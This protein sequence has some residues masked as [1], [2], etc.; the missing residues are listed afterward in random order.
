MKKTIIS[1]LSIL[2]LSLLVCNVFA[3]A[4][5]RTG[6]TRGTSPSFT[7][8]S[9][10]SPTPKPRS[11]STTNNT[12]KPASYSS[13]TA[14]YP[15]ST[16]YFSGD[17]LSNTLIFGTILLMLNDT[18]DGEPTYVDEEGNVYT[19]ADLEEMEVQIPEDEPVEDDLY[20]ETVSFDENETTTV[21]P[22][23]IETASS[24]ENFEDETYYEEENHSFN[25]LWLILPLTIVVIARSFFRRTKK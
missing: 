2:V 10:T 15:K 6:G 24:Y 11:S 12:S 3:E 4:K 19:L 1:V 9:T 5:T 7:K 14:K 22:E 20:S 16:R 17:I 8:P 23:E 18:N 13:L 21:V 25:W